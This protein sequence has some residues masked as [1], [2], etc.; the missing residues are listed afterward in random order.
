MAIV[1]QR[2]ERVCS[3]HSVSLLR[4]DLPYLPEPGVHSAV[5]MGTGL[6]A[7][8]GPCSSVAVPH[9][10]PLVCTVFVDLMK[11]R[12]EQQLAGGTAPTT[13]SMA[14]LISRRSRITPFLFPSGTKT[15]Q[16]P[17]T[18]ED[19]PQINVQSIPLPVPC[20]HSSRALHNAGLQQLL[21]GHES[22]GLR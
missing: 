10:G 12:R 13:P 17:S 9:D 6:S 14:K 3:E 21:V 11:T 18:L 5:D 16:P 15:Q 19:G 8:V 20:M 4:V 22:T 7:A 1:A 2:W